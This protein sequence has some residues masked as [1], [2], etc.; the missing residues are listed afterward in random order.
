[1]QSG[2]G[3][4]DLSRLQFS[5]NPVASRRPLVHTLLET[6]DLLA[7]LLEF[8]FLDLRQIRILRKG[9][10]HKSGNG[11]DTDQ[12]DANMVSHHAKV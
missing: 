4:L 12:A 2:F 10:G 3:N 6:A 11:Q 1:M 8:L 5:G 7:N 9:A